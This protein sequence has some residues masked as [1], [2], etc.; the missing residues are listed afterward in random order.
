MD[1]FGALNGDERF[2]KLFEQKPSK[3]AIDD[4]KK[5]VKAFARALEKLR[6]NKD[7]FISN[8]IRELYRD[9]ETGEVKKIDTSGAMDK[10]QASA[11]V[12]MMLKKNYRQE[13]LL[14]D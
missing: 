3:K 14:E 13:D 7:K 9:P 8:S 2:N 5:D 6:E 1:N 10:S 11:W 12:E 4:A